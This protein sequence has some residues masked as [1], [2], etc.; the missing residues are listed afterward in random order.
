MKY[1]AVIFDLFGTLVDSYSVQGYN[2]LLADMASALQLPEN[3]FSQLWRDTTYERGIGIF[4]TTGES[5]RYIFKMLKSPV[6]EENIDTLKQALVKEK[7][8]TEDYLANWQRAQADF[9]NYKRRSEQEKE[10]TAKF[11]NIT[12]M[13][14]L[15]P[16]LDDLERALV[17]IP[18]RLAKITWVDGIRLI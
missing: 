9:I 10:E 1:K 4:K 5:I 6:S 12:L 14:T 13:L 11:A 17:S 7:E 15:L 3:D 8:K 16:A 2:K 18:P